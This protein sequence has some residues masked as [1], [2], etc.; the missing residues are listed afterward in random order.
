MVKPVYCGPGLWYDKQTGHIQFEE[1]LPE[2]WL[3]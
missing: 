1:V 3:T 2:R